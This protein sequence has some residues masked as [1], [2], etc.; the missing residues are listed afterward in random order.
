MEKRVDFCKTI[1]GMFEEELNEKL[2][3]FRDTAHFCL[4]G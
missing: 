3:I 2:I 1:T 4:N